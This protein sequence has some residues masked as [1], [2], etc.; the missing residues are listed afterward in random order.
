MEKLVRFWRIC[1]RLYAAEASTGEGARLFG[2]RWNSP[3]VRVVYASS[4]LALAAV[5]T[6]VNLEPNLRPAD[7]VSIQGA[8]PDTI[9]IDRLD[10]KT[11]PARWH[12]SRDESLRRFGDAWI[13]SGKSAVLLVPSAAIRGEWNVLLNPAHS[14]F[15]AIQLRDPEPFEFDTRMF[16]P[17]SSTPEPRRRRPHEPPKSGR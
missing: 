13:R 8:I 9:E 14:V 7:L 11:L 4:S 3:G 15:G 17:T 5:E 6:F 10:V 16:R 12:E 1:R 2:G